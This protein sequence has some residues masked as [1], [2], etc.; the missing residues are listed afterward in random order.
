MRGLHLHQC[1]YARV[2][3]AA[4]EASQSSIKGR[5]ACQPLGTPAGHCA[6]TCYGGRRTGR[7]ADCSL[8][9]PCPVECA[10]INPIQHL[11]QRLNSVSERVKVTYRDDVHDGAAETYVAP[12]ARQFGFRAPTETDA[13]GE[14]RRRVFDP[15]PPPP[16]HMR[17]L[18]RPPSAA[19][20]VRDD[21]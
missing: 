4:K 20:G 2:P 10:V 3:E 19:P 6:L 13:I 8:M 12:C 15:L 9:R 11:S 1:P 7:S 18:A 21:G 5:E 17:Q 16:R 14:L